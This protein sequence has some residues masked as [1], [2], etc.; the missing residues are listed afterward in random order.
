LTFWRGFEDGV[1]DVLGFEGVAEGGRRGFSCLEVFEEIGDVVDE[2][3]FVADLEAGDPPVV[4]VGHVAVGDV[5][6]APAADDGFVAVVEPV[7]AVEVVE[8]PLDGGV[9]AVDFE[10]VEGFVAA[11]VAGGFE[12]G[13][14][15]VVEAGEEGA[16]VVDADGFDL[17]GEVC[18]VP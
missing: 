2:G 5:D 12:G 14:G 18:C 6:G 13:E 17:A 9:F 16:G 10:G 4:H 15:A 1:A 3:V 8:V 7:E 11:G